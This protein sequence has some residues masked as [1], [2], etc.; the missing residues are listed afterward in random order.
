[1]RWI[2]TRTTAY[3][4][5]F[6]FTLV[7]FSASTS[8]SLAQDEEKAA[9]PKD[10]IATPAD[11]E[12]GDDK[13]AAEPNPFLDYLFIIVPIVLLLLG[14]VYGKSADRAHLQRL[15]KQLDE[16]DNMLVTNLKSF[17]LYIEGGP[18]PELVM[19]EVVVATDYLKSFLASWRNLFGGEM[20]SYLS[21]LVRAR[22]EVLVRLQAEAQQRG[23]NALCNVRFQT[24]D[25]AGAT[26]KRS[27]TAVALIAYAT[28]YTASS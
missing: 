26:G 22:L 6:L 21:L 7:N 2:S 13:F 17:P 28:A 18:P 14:Y 27:A 1:M 9:E 5:F 15:Q 25:I 10:A 23:H 8:S 3:L 12:D 19:S 24:A 20:K 11:V 4:A 16:M